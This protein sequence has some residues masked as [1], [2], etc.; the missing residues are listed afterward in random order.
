MGRQTALLFSM[1]FLFFG[2]VNQTEEPDFSE[3]AAFFPIEVGREWIYASDSIVW[4]NIGSV[5]D[6]TRSYLKEIA[7]ETFEAE[8]GKVWTEWLRYYSS[9]SI[10]WIPLHSW[11]VRHG[12]GQ[13]VRV[14]ENISFI[15]FVY[16][17][18]DGTRWDGNVYFDSDRFIQLQGE[19]I[20]PFQNWRYRISTQNIDVPC[21]QE[22]CAVIK[23]DHIDASTLLDRR[24]S[25]EYFGEGV[26]LIRKQMVIL[27]GDGTRPNDA[28]EKKAQKGFIHTLTL[29][30]YKP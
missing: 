30:S 11:R 23:V 21:V 28:W 4:L 22:K 25:V 1:C 16:P 6:T 14:E 15:K 2:C 24:K 17:F 9:D 3:G 18:R 27:D 13:L 12:E 29:L 26:G 8:D 19:R 5:I 20:Q 10:R 7:G